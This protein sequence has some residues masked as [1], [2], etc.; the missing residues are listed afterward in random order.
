[1]TSKYSGETDPSEIERTYNIRKQQTW[2]YWVCSWEPMK[3][4]TI[5]TPHSH[6]FKRYLAFHQNPILLKDQNMKTI[7]TLYQCKWWSFTN[8]TQKL[9]QLLR[10]LKYLENK[11]LRN[12]E[13]LQYMRTEDSVLLSLFIT[14]QSPMDWLMFLLIWMIEISEH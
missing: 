10:L 4:A 7:S 13:N 8:S 6:W 1:M 12:R 5:L 11:S 2:F 3:S 9:R 14:N